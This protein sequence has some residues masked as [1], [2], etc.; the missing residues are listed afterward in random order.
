VSHDRFHT[1]YERNGHLKQLD[2]TKC[3][4]LERLKFGKSHVKFSIDNERFSALKKR[5]KEPLSN[6]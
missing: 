5:F 4:A 3:K 6:A 2:V 1:F